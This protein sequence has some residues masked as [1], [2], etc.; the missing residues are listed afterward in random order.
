MMDLREQQQLVNS[1]PPTSKTFYPIISTKRKKVTDFQ[2]I[3]RLNWLYK[4]DLVNLLVLLIYF[5]VDP[6]IYGII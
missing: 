3:L 5:Y 6:A 4:E 2:Y 1:A